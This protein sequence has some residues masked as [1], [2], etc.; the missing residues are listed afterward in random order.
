MFHLK[1]LRKIISSCLQ[2][3]HK[4]KYRS[5]VFPAIGTGNLNFPRAITACIFFDELVD[6]SKK[7][8]KTPI[9]SVRIV[10]F[11]KDEST[12]AAF[13][14]ELNTRKED[15]K[16]GGVQQRFG[17]GE[18]DLSGEFAKGKAQDWE[19]VRESEVSTLKK[20]GDGIMLGPSNMLNRGMSLVAA[21]TLVSQDQEPFI[22]MLRN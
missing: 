3:A 5:V 9:Q 19:M 7:Y 11:G 6:F 16:H 13:Q 4:S 2:I 21:Q 12:Y 15:R 17:E 8:P 22:Q 18:R 1:V 14:K 10:V 20:D